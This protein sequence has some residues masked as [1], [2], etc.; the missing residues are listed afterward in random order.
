MWLASISLTNKRGD[1]VCTP[2]WRNM[3]WQQAFA[4]LDEATHGVGHPEHFR[5]FRMQIT[6]CKHVP[7][8]EDEIAV[9]PDGWM[10]ARS[11]SLA[12][13]PVEALET[14][15]L[16]EGLVSVRSCEN[17]GKNMLRDQYGIVK[18]PEMWL[19]EDCGDCA[20]CLAREE[21]FVQA[22]H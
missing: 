19:P 6:L 17:P 3:Q 4:L 20:P 18:N 8:R 12:G 2:S 9:L 11:D 22:G 13:G 10:E 5:K 21:L 7:L 16:P 14:V 15:G 1:K